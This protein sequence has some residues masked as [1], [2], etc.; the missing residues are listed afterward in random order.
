MDTGRRG[1]GR[2]IARGRPRRG[3]WDGVFALADRV[4]R[5]DPARA[6]LAPL[7][8]RINLLASAV[9]ARLEAD[10]WPHLRGVTV[11]WLA[12]SR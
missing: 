12:N 9:G 2:G 3:Y 8:T 11:A 10:F 1:R 5:A 6:N 4:D 7:R